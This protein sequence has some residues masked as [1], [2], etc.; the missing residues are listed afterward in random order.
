VHHLY[1]FSKLADDLQSGLAF[2]SR[3]IDETLCSCPLSYQ[4][5]FRHCFVFSFDHVK[6]DLDSF[7]RNYLA[8]K[9]FP[10]RQV[11]KYCQCGLLLCE[12]ILTLKGSWNVAAND[13]HKLGDEVFKITLMLLFVRLF[14]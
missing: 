4:V 5:L 2:E 6:K 7:I 12:L 9:Y 13:L 8:A 3:E 10:E 1:L 14:R 11:S